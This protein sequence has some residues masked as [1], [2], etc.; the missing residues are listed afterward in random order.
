M[1]EILKADAPLLQK[2]IAAAAVNLVLNSALSLF[3]LLMHL[4]LCWG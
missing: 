4:S 3:I 1:T 2:A